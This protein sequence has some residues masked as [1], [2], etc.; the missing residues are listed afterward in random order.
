MS[1]RRID[2]IGK[3]DATTWN[4][5]QLP[6]GSPN[7]VRVISGILS[8]M[9]TGQIMHAIVQQTGKGA[10]KV[11]LNGESF[12][13]KG[14]PASLA[15]KE[16]AFIAQQSG[17]QANAK[18]ELFWLGA[19]QTGLF[20]KKPGMATAHQT[21]QHRGKQQSLPKQVNILSSL[22]ADLKSGQVIS[23]RIDAIQGKQ[24]NISIWLQ[25]NTDASKSTRHQILTTSSN[26][27]QQGQHITGKI[28]SDQYNKPMLEI[29][30]QQKSPQ[31]EAKTAKSIVSQ[32]SEKSPD[33]TNAKL[34][35]FK[36]AVGQSTSAFVQ[37]R[38]ANGH[39][40]L[41]IQGT[42]VE[43]PAP[44][45]IQKGDILV[46][47]MHKPP[48]GFQLL[49]IHKNATAKAL[50]TLKANLP[51]SS[52][53]IAQTMTAIRNLLPSLPANTLPQ[54]NN[55]PPLEATL[56]A[57]ALTAEQPLNGER[58]TQM[59]RHAGA[60][61]ESKLLNLSQSLS[62]NASQAALNPSLQHD[63]KSIMLQLANPQ[64]SKA[65]QSQTIKTLTE[66]AQ[67]GVARIETGQALNVLAQMQG[68][69]MRIELPMLVNQQLVNVQL[70]IQQN[71]SY[72]SDDLD[73]GKGSN[74]SY[75]IL[76]ALE[77]SQL[78]NIRVDANI[79]ETSVH[80]RIHSESP[81]SNQFIADNL[82]RLEERLQNLG[83]NETYL[84]ASKQPPEAEKQQRFE[85]LTHM[86]PAPASLNLLDIRI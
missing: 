75:N 41:N 62:I 69:G 9:N 2:A 28:I 32:R 8:Q 22:P 74:P 11:T 72:E 5:L 64:S 12:L 17:S 4:A 79:S 27:L 30:A 80:A 49:S 53:P 76:F 1:E 54:N 56:R 10:F 70:S 73:E 6:K 47:K 40:Q 36:L 84:L 85:Q 43:A 24:M 58:I 45:G 16:V 44:K 77:L 52:N 86:A 25:D 82:Q 67:Q 23:A 35:H 55:L 19:S 42:I 37:Q 33:I 71:E 20:G 78:G 26:G 7:L 81:S 68:E 29:T 63:L 50:A 21:T 66:L 18:T 51:I 48:A 34:A 46:L 60:G 13:I 57:N 31:I 14:L 59:I 3:A 65:Q 15:G 38:L 83:F 61:L 39:V